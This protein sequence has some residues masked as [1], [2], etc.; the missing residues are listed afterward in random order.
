MESHDQQQPSND[1]VAL[2]PLRAISKD[3]GEAA[4]TFM[5]T[6]I[7]AATT[8]PMDVCS[9]S[10]IITQSATTTTSNAFAY[11][12]TTP[13]ASKKT[14]DAKESRQPFP[15]KVYEMLQDADTKGFSNIVSWNPMG[16]GFM[17]HNK[18]KFTSDIVPR[19]F[20]LTKYKSFQRQVSASL[21]RGGFL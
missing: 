18:D 9:N 13:S 17:V 21:Y 3:R 8:G 11:S 20:N 1:V 4:A 12:A 16:T 5:S 6:P 19:Y 10:S 2:A 7:A 14:I 15:A